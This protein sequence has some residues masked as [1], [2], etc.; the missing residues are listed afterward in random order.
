MANLA[1]EYIRGTRAVINDVDWFFYEFEAECREDLTE[2]G[3]ELYLS[4]GNGKEF[5]YNIVNAKKIKKENRIKIEISYNFV[6]EDLLASFDFN[7]CQILL[8][9]QEDKVIFTQEFLDFLKNN[10]VKPAEGLNKTNPITS[11]LRGR[12]KAFDLDSKIYFQ[13][14]VLNLLVKPW[15]GHLFEENF[16]GIKVSASRDDIYADTFMTKKRLKELQK[17]REALSPFFYFH[18]KKLVFNLDNNYAW[19]DF[20]KEISKVRISSIERES[21]FHRSFF[22]LDEIIK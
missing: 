8:D 15:V 5:N 6:W 1:V 13:D 4:S 22:V 14:M 9:W 19:N 16:E 21:G 18:K 20:F 11:I 2:I 12:Q 7:C 10:V 17:D 3:G